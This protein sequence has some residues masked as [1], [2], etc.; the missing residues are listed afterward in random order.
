M[1]FSETEAFMD[2]PS[3]LMIFNNEDARKSFY[4][5]KNVVLKACQKRKSWKIVAHLSGTAF[6]F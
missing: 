1:I 6:G 2:T 4:F 5:Y 3:E